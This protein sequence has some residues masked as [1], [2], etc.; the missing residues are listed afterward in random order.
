MGC[1]SILVK[2]NNAVHLE[3]SDVFD[4]GLEVVGKSTSTAPVDRDTVVLDLRSMI[5]SV[6]ESK[7]Q[8][9]FKQ[10]HEMMIEIADSLSEK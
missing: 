9:N 2:K 4:V 8:E 3:F 7:T 6:V 1:L 5:E 10:L